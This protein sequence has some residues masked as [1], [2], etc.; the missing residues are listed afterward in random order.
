M[1]MSHQEIAEVLEEKQGTVK[2]RLHRARQA[3]KEI[4]EQECA[5]EQDERNVLVCIPR[6]DDSQAGP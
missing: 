1:G 2:V 6:E 4:L 5:F 3:L